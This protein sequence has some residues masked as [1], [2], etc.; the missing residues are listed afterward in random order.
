MTIGRFFFRCGINNSHIPKFCKSA[1]GAIGPSKGKDG[2]RPKNNDKKIILF[3]VSLA[4]KKKTLM[5]K[6]NIY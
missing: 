5:I 6:T 2:E 3:T 4:S 1:E